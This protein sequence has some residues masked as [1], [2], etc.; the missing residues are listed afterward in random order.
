LAAPDFSFVRSSISPPLPQQF[1]NSQIYSRKFNLINDSNALKYVHE[2]EK[3]VLLTTKMPNCIVFNFLRSL[4]APSM[5]A[6][7]EKG[8]KKSLLS[9][10]Q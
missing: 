6:D 3:K 1:F 9:H 4:H 8:G 5:K 10:K 7:E 2:G